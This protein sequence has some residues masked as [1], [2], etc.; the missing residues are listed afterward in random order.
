MP[1]KRKYYKSYRQREWELLQSELAITITPEHLVK[2]GIS[3][4]NP[5]KLRIKRDQFHKLEISIPVDLSVISSG[6][7]ELLN[8]SNMDGFFIKGPTLA[9]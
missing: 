7:L 4:Q 2:I 5:I 3:I 9:Q 1:H 8:P 6:F